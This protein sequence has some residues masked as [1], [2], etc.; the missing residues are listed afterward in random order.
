MIHQ[1]RKYINSVNVELKQWLYRNGDQ[2]L[3]NTGGWMKCKVSANINSATGMFAGN[4]IT[5]YGN[6]ASNLEFTADGIVFSCSA[7]TSSGYIRNN[8]IN[9][10]ERAGG[11]SSINFGTVNQIPLKYK[12]LKAVAT[13]NAIYCSFRSG[14]ANSSNTDINTATILR[15]ALTNATNISLESLNG[16]IVIGMVIVIPN[17]TSD[18]VPVPTATESYAGKYTEIYL[19]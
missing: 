16:Y 4:Q 18:G 14:A 8:A 15:K 6:A 3:H 5:I 1:P 17:K 9:G 2:C 7:S 13:G 10:Y 19:V 11:S 12:Q